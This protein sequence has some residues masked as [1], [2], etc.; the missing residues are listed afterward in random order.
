[1]TSTQQSD[2]AFGFTFAVVFVVIAAIGW[3]VFDTRLYWSVALA[4]AF[5]LVALAAPIILLPLNRLWRRLGLRLGRISNYLLLGAFL[6]LVIWPAGLLMRLLGRDPMNRR[7]RKD[8]A[9]Y[10]TTVGRQSN[11]ET[12]HDMF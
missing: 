2:R 6:Y 3:L 11:A 7:I 1:M 9:S 5:A 10:W 12:L 8:A 4:V